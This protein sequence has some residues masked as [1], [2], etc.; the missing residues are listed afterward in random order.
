MSNPLL[1][2]ELRSRCLENCGYDKGRSWSLPKPISLKELQEQR[3][4][5]GFP[6]HEHQ[7][8]ETDR[9]LIIPDMETKDV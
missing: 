8:E 1:V 2:V 3:E 6:K 9:I 5:R 7:T 4:E